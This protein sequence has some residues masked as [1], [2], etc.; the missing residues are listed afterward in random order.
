MRRLVKS[1]GVGVAAAALCLAIGLGAESMFRKGPSRPGDA[2]V[3]SASA[4]ASADDL[5]VATSDEIVEMSTWRDPYLGPISLMV[6]LVASAWSLRKARKSE[7]E[8]AAR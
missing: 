3:A 1:L 8:S 5:T 7:T 2:A 6:L 4:A